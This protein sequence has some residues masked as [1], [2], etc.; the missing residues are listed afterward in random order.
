MPPDATRPVGP[1][2]QAGCLDAATAGDAGSPVCAGDPDPLAEAL[3][4][5]AD[6]ADDQAVRTWLRRMAG[7]AEAKASEQSPNASGP[8]L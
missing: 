2:R 7:D 5:A 3:R 8:G 1:R 6:R 4:Q